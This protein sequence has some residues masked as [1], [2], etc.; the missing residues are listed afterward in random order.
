MAYAN[1]TTAQGYY[2]IIS[3]Y[4]IDLPKVEQ[5]NI[6]N[7][8]I[9]FLNGSNKSD[10]IHDYGAA[11]KRNVQDEIDRLKKFAVRHELTL[12]K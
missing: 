11:G 3:H 10:I 6:V 12:A 1:N 5:N 2:N 9:S 4:D 7:S 8:S